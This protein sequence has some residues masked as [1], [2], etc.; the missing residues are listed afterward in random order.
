MTAGKLYTYPGGVNAFKAL[1][2]AE[3]AG[4]KLELPAFEM[5]KTNKTD[6]FL[7]LNPFGKVRVAVGDPAGSAPPGLQHRTL[8]GALAACPSEPAA[9]A[10]VPVLETK[11]GGIFESNAIARYVARLGADKGLAGATPFEAVRCLPSPR[12]GRRCSRR[13][14]TRLAPVLLLLLLCGRRR[15][16]TCGRTMRATRS[17][18]R[19]SPGC[20]R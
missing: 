17:A 6:K 18:A 11:E 10:Q 14:I 3:Y 7:A 1:I 15:R 20:C 12:A 19:C 5:G 16:W 13:R 8:C 4:Q 2:A 9:A